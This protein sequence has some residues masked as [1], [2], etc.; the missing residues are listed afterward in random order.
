VKVATDPRKEPSATGGARKKAIV[1]WRAS[2]PSICEIK[3]AGSAQRV[4]IN[5]L[6]E[7]RGNRKEVRAALAFN[8]LTKNLKPL[9]ER[10]RC[11]CLTC[12]ESLRVRRLDWGRAQVFFHAVALIKLLLRLRRMHG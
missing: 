1:A 6:I 2:S 4:R 7:F 5:Q 11:P 3:P 10:G 12:S 9:W 8:R